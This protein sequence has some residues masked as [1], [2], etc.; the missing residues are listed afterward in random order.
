MTRSSVASAL[1]RGLPVIVLL[2]LVA[3]PLVSGP[4]DARAGG[5]FSFGSRGGRTFSAPAMTPTAPRYAQPFQRTETPNVGQAG[6]PGRRFGFGSGL[7]AGFLGA[8]LMGSLFGGG[9]FSGIAALLGLLVKLALVGGIILL[10]LRLVRGRM[11][12]PAMA[13]IPAGPSARQGP[14]PGAAPSGAAAL[15]IEPTD[16]AAFEAALIAI[17]EAYSREDLGSLAR[18]ATPEMVRHLA[19]DVEGNRQRGLRNDISQVRLVRGDLAEAWREGSA[20]YATV[21][22]RFAAVDVMVDRQSGAV[23]S[24]DAVRPVEATEL[25]TFRRGAGEGWRLSAIQQAG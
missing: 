25:W 5:G 21:A 7:L 19:A 18:F 10:L 11:A 6:V 22:M 17:Q 24:G 3:G 23:A 1:R 9:F 16:Y 13:G 15:S 20:A 4:A 12:P 2:S 14:L 8:G